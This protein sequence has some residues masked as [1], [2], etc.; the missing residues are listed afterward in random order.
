MH[1]NENQR[2]YAPTKALTIKLVVWK[3]QKFF[4]WHLQS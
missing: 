1:F 3:N 2:Q 4:L